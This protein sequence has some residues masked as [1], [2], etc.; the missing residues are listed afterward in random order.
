MTQPAKAAERAQALGELYEQWLAQN[1]GAFIDP[2]DDPV[3]VDAARM[4]MGLGPL[5]AYDAGQEV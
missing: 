3:F 4:I 5:E 2:D 1:P